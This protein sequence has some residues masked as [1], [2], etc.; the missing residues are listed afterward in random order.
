VRDS[1][2]TDKTNEYILRSM[3]LATNGTYLA[4]T[5][6]SGIGGSHEE[7]L[8]DEYRVELLN[9][10]MRRIIAEYSFAYNCAQPDSTQ[11]PTQQQKANPNEVIA[12]P[13]PTHGPVKLTFKSGITDLFLCDLSG[14]ILERIPVNNR[15]GSANFDLFQYPSGVYIIRYINEEKK[16]GAIQVVVRH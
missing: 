9:Q 2:G 1:S 5:N 12:T 7:P 16:T 3:A 8:T 11:Y 13:N 10:A 4:V 6:H 14:K 15:D